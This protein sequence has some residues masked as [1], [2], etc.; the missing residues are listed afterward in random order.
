MTKKDKAEKV[1][2]R[3]AMNE[4]HRLRKLNWT[5]R[6]LGGGAQKHWDACT[7]LAKLRRTR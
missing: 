5:R 4:Y 2:V 6:W 3:T 7:R 1:V